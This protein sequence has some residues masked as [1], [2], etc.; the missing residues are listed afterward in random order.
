M[1]LR[2]VEKDK[3]RE[4]VVR[5]KTKKKKEKEKKDENIRKGVRG[6]F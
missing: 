1:E 4:K 5:V 6:S 3:V 2:A